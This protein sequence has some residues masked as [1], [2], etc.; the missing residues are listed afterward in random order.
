M[1]GPCPKGHWSAN[2][3]LRLPHRHLTPGRR[4]RVARAFTDYDGHRHEA[5]ET[6]TFLGASFSPHEDGQ[7]LFVSLDGSQE[8]DIRLQWRPETQGAVLDALGDFIQPVE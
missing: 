7:S 6:W 8:W 2:A 4:Y 3:G 5:G 1:Y